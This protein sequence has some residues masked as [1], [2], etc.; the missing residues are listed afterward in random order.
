[1][2][3]RTAQPLLRQLA[4]RRRRADRVGDRLRLRRGLS[5]RACTRAE[6]KPLPT[7]PK[8]RSEFIDAQTPSSPRRAAACSTA[9]WRASRRRRRQAALHRRCPSPRHWSCSAHTTAKS[10]RP[11]AG[12]RNSIAQRRRTCASTCASNRSSRTT[13]AKSP[14]G[15]GAALRLDITNTGKRVI[16]R[17]VLR[18]DFRDAAANTWQRCPGSNSRVRSSPARPAARRR[19]CCSIRSTTPPLLEGHPAQITGTPARIVYAGG[20]TLDPERNSRSS[21]RSRARK[22]E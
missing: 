22:I 19:P 13:R 9:S 21:R 8:A 4:F 5:L 2:T 12:I 10:R 16:D 17:I 1:M 11:R 7:D 20:E 6:D 3:C 14:A 15:Q 18:I